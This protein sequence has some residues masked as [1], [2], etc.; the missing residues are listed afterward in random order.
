MAGFTY[1]IE[2]VIPVLEFAMEITA[3]LLEYSCEVESK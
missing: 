3:Y 2:N 1:P